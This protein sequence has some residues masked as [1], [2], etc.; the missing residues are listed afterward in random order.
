MRRES[1]NVAA[2]EVLKKFV[3]LKGLIEEVLAVPCPDQK[4]AT[5]TRGSRTFARGFLI[6]IQKAFMTSTMSSLV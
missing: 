2:V 5:S 3:I 1:I 6:F 4:A